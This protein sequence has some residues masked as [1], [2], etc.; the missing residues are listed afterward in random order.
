MTE[1]ST[2]RDW[3]WILILLNSVIMS[4][5]LY[6]LWTKLSGSD[7]DVEFQTIFH[8]KNCYTLP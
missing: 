5:Y 3:T 2:P 4:L 1:T 8:A 6:I 7:D